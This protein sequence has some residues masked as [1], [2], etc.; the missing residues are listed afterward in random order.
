VPGICLCF[1]VHRPVIL[2]RYTFFDIGRHHLYEDQEANRRILNQLADSC[3]LPANRL[4][5]RLM[6]KSE[7]RFRVAFAL[8][9]AMIHLCEKYR[10]DIM[11]GFRRLAD[12]GCVEFL[13]EADPHS[14][15]FLF[16][17]REFREQIEAHKKKIQELF[18]QNPTTFHCTDLIYSNELAGVAEEMGHSAFLAEGGQGLPGFQGPDFV[19]QPAD[20]A[21]LKLLL[22]NYHL[23]ADIRLHFS[24]GSRN[25]H[26]FPA[27]WFAER[28][29]HSLENS[30]GQVVNLFLDYE[31]SGKYLTPDRGNS[32][33]LQ[34]LSAEMLGQPDFHFQL[35]A[36]IA[37]RYDP[38]ARLDVTDSASGFDIHR[39]LTTVAGNAMQQD[40]L[41]ALYDLEEAVRKRKDADCLAIW[42][43]LQT[44]DYFNY[45]CTEGF[46]DRVRRH[47]SGP[48][49][50][51]YE[52]YINYMNILEDFSR[53]LQS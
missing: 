49:G 46:A 22:R 13:N 41:R 9:G 42:R 35:P 51:P 31:T 14:L 16:S 40:A 3:Y 48:Y 34:A 25:G 37:Q 5:L 39:N 1:Q 50:S 11:E 24:D 33:F 43:M 21:R 26:P 30:G 32:E 44:S 15:A 8:S 36:E 12:T 4:L 45:M 28:I 17:P 53:T 18:G 20:C 52:S 29:L 27:G 2:K 19:Y 10:Q 47:D 38:Q 6:E 7:G 23:S